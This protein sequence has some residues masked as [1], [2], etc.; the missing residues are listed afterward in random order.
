M[1][2]EESLS[3]QRRKV[4][5]RVGLYMIMQQLGDVSAAE[6]ASVLEEATEE[7]R[8]LDELDEPIERDCA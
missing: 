4:Q 3:E 1:T 8:L 5:E 6:M 2:Y 7:V